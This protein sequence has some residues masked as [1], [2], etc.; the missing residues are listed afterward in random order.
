MEIIKEIESD[1]IIDEETREF[2]NL[3]LAIVD[4]PALND[5]IKHQFTR[6]NVDAS[7]IK[8]CKRITEDRIAKLAKVVRSVKF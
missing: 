2:I 5:L 6:Q 1:D 7:F 4:R 3:C 8:K